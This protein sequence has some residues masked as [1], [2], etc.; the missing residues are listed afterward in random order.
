M[1]G[2]SWVANEAPM[3]DDLTVMAKYSAKAAQLHLLRNRVRI[4]HA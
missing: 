2:C 3:N 4:R 1:V